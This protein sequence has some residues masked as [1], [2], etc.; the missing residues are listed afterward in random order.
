MGLIRK[1]IIKRDESWEEIK[2]VVIQKARVKK[3][4]KYFG[5]WWT[6]FYLSRSALQLVLMIMTEIDYNWRFIL[7]SVLERYWKIEKKE[8][9]RYY[10]AIRELRKAWIVEKEKKGQYKVNVRYFWRGRVDIE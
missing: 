8:K 10:K 6:I 3:F 4:T 2:E 5:L 1:T 7:D 9:N